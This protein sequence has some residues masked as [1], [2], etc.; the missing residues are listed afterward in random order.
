LLLLPLF[1]SLVLVVNPGRI[2]HSAV[3]EFAGH[4]DNSHEKV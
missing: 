4:D 2:I 3:I 1:I